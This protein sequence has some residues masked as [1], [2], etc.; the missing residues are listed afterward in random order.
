MPNLIE[1]G[2]SAMRMQE[3]LYESTPLGCCAG[4]TQTSS[5]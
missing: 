5:I 4:W 1:I 3:I 2:E